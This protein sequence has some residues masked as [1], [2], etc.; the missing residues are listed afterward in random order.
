MRGHIRVSSLMQG[1]NL[2]KYD[3]T[4]FKKVA[5]TTVNHIRNSLS[6]VKPLIRYLLTIMV[7]LLLM[8]QVVIGAGLGQATSSTGGRGWQDFIVI[9]DALA[10]FYPHMLGQL[11]EE[12]RLEALHNTVGAWMDYREWSRF[13][14]EWDVYIARLIRE[15][16][17]VGLPIGVCIRISCS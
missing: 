3:V 12:Y 4:Y 9:G 15:A 1:D 2:V 10:A 7:I 11:K 17:N 8:S 14:A 16:H 13:P 5:Y 6:G